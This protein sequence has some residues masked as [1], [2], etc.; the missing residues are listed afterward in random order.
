MHYINGRE[1][2]IGDVIIARS[3]P[4]VFTGVVIDAQPGATSCNLS[5]VPVILNHWQCCTAG[6]CQHVD[7]ALPKKKQ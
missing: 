5:V 3:G 2:K 6:E 7:D 4:A 1:A